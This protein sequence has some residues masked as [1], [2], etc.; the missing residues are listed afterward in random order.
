MHVR[1]QEVPRNAVD[2]KKR[3]VRPAKHGMHHG[4]FFAY[5]ARWPLL[6]DDR[7]EDQMHQVK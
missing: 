5:A 4:V 3:L 1:R 6:G 7:R 2:S